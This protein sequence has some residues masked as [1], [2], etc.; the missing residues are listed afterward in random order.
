MT[1]D[2]ARIELFWSK[3]DATGDC[4]NWTGGSYR[5]YG[6]FS[7]GDKRVARA[8]RFAYEILVGKIPNGLVID[9]LCKNTLCVNPSH[10]E[11]VTNGE[12]VRRG[13]S[14][15]TQWRRRT[16]CESG[17]ELTVDNVVQMSD[18]AR[19][20]R[21]RECTRQKN[22]EAYRQNREKRVAY[23]REYRKRMKEDR[24]EQD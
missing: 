21:C 2:A 14:V 20:R 3:V 23:A 24:N 8:H 15:S 13:A 9:H 7:I 1:V 19:G 5:G 11:S 22:R 18:K 16:H 10:L 6:Q 12:N 17:H 4:W